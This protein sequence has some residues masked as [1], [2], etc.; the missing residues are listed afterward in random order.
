[1]LDGGRD[2]MDPGAHRPKC[3]CHTE[4]SVVVRL[5]ATA[6]ENDLLRARINQC[7]DLFASGLD[8]GASALAE[9]V[10]RGGVAELGREKRKHG[11][12]D[13]GLDGRGGV[14]IEVNALH[15]SQ[16]LG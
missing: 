5:R 2:D 6:G 9:S 3:L 1:M 14:V 15:K 13:G 11:V 16:E 8:R 10:N 4:D 7:S 12:E